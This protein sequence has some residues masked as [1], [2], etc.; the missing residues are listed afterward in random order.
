M[1]QSPAVQLVSKDIASYN[2]SPFW[3]HIFPEKFNINI[4]TLKRMW[5][6]RD[7]S[8]MKNKHGW[9]LDNTL[10][11]NIAIE[12]HYA[13]QIFC[14]APLTLMKEQLA[15]LFFSVILPSDTRVVETL[16]VATST[17]SGSIVMKKATREYTNIK[18]YEAMFRLLRISHT[19]VSSKRKYLRDPDAWT[20]EPL[21][22]LEANRDKTYLEIRFNWEFI[23][24]SEIAQC[25]DT[26]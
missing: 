4:K 17:P 7:F 24:L 11:C 12:I 16:E 14:E 13:Y 26:L 21:L 5:V 18:S 20:S 23:L 1:S 15:K 2:L 25:V 9:S 6:H 10:A 19:L 22:F 3:P 8:D